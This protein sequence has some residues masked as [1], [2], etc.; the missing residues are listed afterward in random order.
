MMTSRYAPLLYWCPGVQSPAELA[1]AAL[2]ARLESGPSLRQRQKKG[3]GEGLGMLYCRF[4]GTRLAYLPER[5]T[6]HP[7]EQGAW[8][9]VDRDFTP[10]QVQRPGARVGVSVQVGPWA[11][12]LPVANPDRASCTLPRVPHQVGGMWLTRVRREHQALA[13][14]AA[15]LG[16]QLRA[17]LLDNAPLR[18][19][20][21][22]IYQFLADAL[23]IHYDLSLAEVLA[24]EVL[25]VESCGRA[26]H[27]VTGFR[28][29][30]T[31]ATERLQQEAAPDGE[32][33]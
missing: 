8:L 20:E 5:Q 15:Y 7:L 32:P 6:W 12:L 19:D 22:D 18:A 2:R 17:A 23:A 24:L 27:V 14:R 9:G 33:A 4:P 28:E 3:P 30:L 11:W 26:L 1:D 10:A 21:G 31:E 25:D 29:V 16:A 13:E